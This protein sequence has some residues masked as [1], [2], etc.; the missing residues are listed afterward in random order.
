ME[1]ADFY[2]VQISVEGFGNDTCTKAIFSIQE[3]AEEY[4]KKYINED[5]K[6]AEGSWGEVP[7]VVPQKWGEYIN[8]FPDWDN[9]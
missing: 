6:R 5:P 9:M 3:E 4:L 1:Q 2:A 8:A 7:R